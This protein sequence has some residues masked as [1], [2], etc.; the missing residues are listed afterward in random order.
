MIKS[1]PVSKAMPLN[2]AAAA[3]PAVVL[4][5]EAPAATQKQME[6]I[7]LLCSCITVAQLDNWKTWS[8][9]GLILKK[10]G[11]PMSVWDELSRK[12][13]KIKRH[14]CAKQCESFKLYPCT[15]NN[16]IAMAKEGKI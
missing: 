1:E 12:S 5:G 15:M 2:T 4:E 11:A 6:D 13:K 8:E 10:L 7:R 14:E 16:L 3:L 9:L